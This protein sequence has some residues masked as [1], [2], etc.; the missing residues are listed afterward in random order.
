M[1]KDNL[2]GVTYKEI[3]AYQE[4][5]RERCGQN[6]IY[7]QT[8]RKIRIERESKRARVRNR[9]IRTEREKR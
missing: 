8:E 4:R 3:V 2:Q 5:E 7:R 1:E 6:E 9:N